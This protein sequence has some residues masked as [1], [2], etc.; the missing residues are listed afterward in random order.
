MA[1]LVRVYPERQSVTHLFGSD[2]FRML[3]DRRTEE[4]LAHMVRINF[5]KA[6]D[7]RR[8]H[9]FHIP[10]GALYI[11]PEP[12]QTGYIPEDDKSFGLSPFRRIAIA[13]GD[14]R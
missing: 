2:F 13:D 1:V 14:C 9:D 4:K 8:A 11:T 3:I 10:T 6:A 5:D 12:N 7:W